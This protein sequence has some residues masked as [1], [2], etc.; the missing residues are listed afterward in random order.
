MHALSSKLHFAAAAAIAAGVLAPQPAHSQ[1]AAGAERAEHRSARLSR[2]DQGFVTDIAQSNLAEIAAGRLAMEMSHDEQ[3]RRFGAAMVE[4]HTR[5]QAQLQALAARKAAALPD[6]PDIR[7]RTDAI[8]LRGLSG[9]AFDQ[10]Y[11]SKAGVA[12]HGRALTLLQQVQREAQDP[13]LRAYADRTLPI[14]LGHLV[15]AQ[16]LASRRQ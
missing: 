5:S 4:D 2:A 15:R 3:I 9:T 10:R 6:G 12:D 14:M 11:I 1:T 16:E 7:H 8:A 13:D